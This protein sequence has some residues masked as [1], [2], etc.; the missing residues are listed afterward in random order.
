MMEGKAAGE[1]RGDKQKGDLLHSHK[2]G[3]FS[4]TP[5][6]TWEHRLRLSGPDLMPVS[7]TLTPPHPSALSKGPPG[8]QTQAR[9]A[10]SA[11]GNSFNAEVPLQAVGDSSP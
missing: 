3:S 9:L 10:L 7:Q 4:L 2:G 1:G 11:C 8:T 5:Q 6:G